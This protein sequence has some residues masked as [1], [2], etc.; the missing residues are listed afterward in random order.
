M[1]R[2]VLAF[3]L[4]ISVCFAAM[5]QKYTISGYITDAAS[6]EPII[7]AAVID[8]KSTMGVVTGNT[9]FYSISL[10]RGEHSL[11]FSYLGYRD[12][13]EVLS[14]ER[15]VQLNIGLE[16]SPEQLE[17]AAVIA[18]RSVT[19]ARSTRMSAIE[20][21]VSQIKAI[22]AI[23]GEVDVIKA[24]QLL[25]GVQ[26]GSE[27][28]AGLYVRGGGADENLLLMD[29][30]PLYNV[31]HLFGFFSVFNAD[32]VKNVT[33]Y[34]GS[35]PA[36][37]GSHL[38]SVIDV[39]LNDGNDSEIHGNVSIGVISSKFNLEGPIV[40]GRTTF[41]VSARR[42]YLDLLAKP[43]FWH[44]NRDMKDDSKN[45]DKVM[46]GYDF[47]DFNAKITHKLLNGDRLSLS[48]YSGDDKA[49]V[50]NK[51]S[52]YYEI[53]DHYYD[54][55]NQKYISIPTGIWNLNKT[56]M[57]M[58]LSWGNLVSSFKWNHELTP[59][60]YMSAGVSFTRYRS[61]LNIKLDEYSS[62]Y[63]NNKEFDITKE[64]IRTRYNSLIGD[65]ALTADFDWSPA[66]GHDVKFG[67]TY[68]YHRFNPGI[69][70]YKMKLEGDSMEE[71]RNFS[72]SVGDKAI[73]AHEAALFAEDNL[74]INPW[75]K[76][77]VGLR[78]SI[79]S[80]K[81]K[82]YFS[83]EPRLSARALITDKISVKASYSEMSQYIHLLCNSNISLP[84]DL[85]VPVTK[86]IKPMRS[87]Q[88]AAGVFLDE[89][90][91]EY[92]VEAYFKT[93]NNL[94][95]Y[96]DGASYFNTSTGWEEKVSLGRGWSYGLEFFVQKKLGK[97]TGWV[98]YTLAKAMRKFDKPGM[99]INNGEPFPAKYDRRH[100]LSATISHQFSK[101]FDISAS[102]VYASGNRGSLSFEK[103]PTEPII[104]DETEDGSS[105]FNDINSYLSGRNNYRMPPYH[106]LDLG[107]NF[108]K[109]KKNGTAIWNI[110]V[111]NAYNHQNPYLLTVDTHYEYDKNGNL[112]D[113]WPVL[114]QVSIFPI[115][116]SV[117]Y[118]FKF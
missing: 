72:Q 42:T 10:E 2:T 35:F 32:A 25:P 21:P 24:L 39:R 74:A 45:Y 105:A 18:H 52:N 19:G 61:S 93:M 89:G 41:N 70:T 59:K 30:V 28:S 79:Y 31:N 112:L 46:G 5:A 17:G 12:R 51:N 40:K 104:M 82:S 1:Q 83:A 69:V 118:T 99:E 107:M 6:G 20:V 71:G 14:L 86:L 50:S 100:D 114:K 11:I 44:V 85:W 110:S 116:P 98:G 113:T 96:K 26:S 38:S 91:F 92:S 108:H 87:R 90:D 22:P 13:A 47:Y 95:E 53:I 106:R 23:G 54:E 94:L 55:E 34:K 103:Y 97:T 60:L 84:S 57:N 73:A 36:R 77:N 43:I 49:H 78:T 102:F 37:F 15:N 76:A 101:R 117:S 29:G 66:V 65:F 4:L 80:L 3:V 64:D 7:G 56:N 62:S 88:T 109:Q 27:G 58:G 16:L 67:S 48:F 81:G 33:L 75:L 68:T 63:Q 115:I 111:Y 8:S 9:G